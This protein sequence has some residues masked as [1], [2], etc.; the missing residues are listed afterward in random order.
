MALLIGREATHGVVASSFT[1]VPATWRAIAVP[2]HYV[3]EEDRQGQDTDYTLFAGPSTERM[4]ASGAIYHDSCGL[5][6]AS[7]L[8]LPTKTIVESGVYDNTFKLA[9]D[10][11]SLSA[12]WRQ[13]RE[14]VQAYQVLNGNVTE[15]ALS[16]EANDDLEYAVSLVA[17][18]ETEIATPG[19]TY[20]AVRP[21]AVWQGTVLLGG[22]AC[23]TLLAGRVTIKR[24][25]RPWW[26]VNATGGPSTIL[27]ERREVGF[28]LDMRLASKAEWDYVKAATTR[29]LQITWEDAGVTIGATSHPRLIVKLGTTAYETGDLDMSGNYPRLRVEGKALYTSGDA[30]SIVVT[31]RST[32]DYTA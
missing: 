24:T 3:P 12:R 5:W 30:S 22:A 21:L 18:P 14:P 2:E 28:T 27:A 19:F 17:Y 10:P 29:S 13:P 6:L 11:P 9:N 8:G 32:V 4:R 1:A 26:S 31:V 15:M 23:S 20:S 7:A 16:F 25:R